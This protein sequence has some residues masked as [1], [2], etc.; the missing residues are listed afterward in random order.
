M[1]HAPIVLPVRRDPPSCVRGPCARHVHQ[2]SVRAQTSLE[3]RLWMNKRLKETLRRCAVLRVSSQVE[4][5]IAASPLELLPGKRTWM[6]SIWRT[7]RG[8]NRAPDRWLREHCKGRSRQQGKPQRKPEMQHGRLHGTCRNGSGQGTN[9][10]LHQKWNW[11]S[12]RTQP[13]KPTP[14]QTGQCGSGRGKCGDCV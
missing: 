8:K 11:R 13:L 4:N 14:L 5:N 12:R 3:M 2:D 10:S 1:K 9:E 6:R 7:S